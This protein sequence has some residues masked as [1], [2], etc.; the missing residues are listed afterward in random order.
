MAYKLPSDIQKLFIDAGLVPPECKELSLA[1]PAA[2]IVCLRY[3]VF[4]T[5][6]QIEDIAGILMAFVEKEKAVQ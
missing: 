1:F 5:M 6:K 2:G 4:V 3:E